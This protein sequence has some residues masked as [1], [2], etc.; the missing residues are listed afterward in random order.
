MLHIIN[1]RVLDVFTQTFEETELWIDGKQIAFRGRSDVLQATETYDAKGA[2]IAPGLID[3][4]L[5]IES[6]LLRP[7][8]LGRLLASHGI[9]TG[10][11]DPHELASVA[12]KDGISFMLADAE[13]SL[14]NFYFMLPSSVPAVDFE[15]AGAT[16]KAADLK[17]FYAHARVNGLA[18]VMDFP[19]VA[20]KESDMMQKIADAQ[21]LNKRIDGH[22][23]GLT[24]EQLA[25][26]RQAGITSDHEATSVAEAEDRLAAG[27]HIL[28][29]QGTVEQDER[30]L[31]P[32]V[33]PQNQHRFSFSTDDKTVSDIVARGSIDESVAIALAEGLP[34]EIVLTMA[35]YNAAQ[36]EGL[37]NVGALN[38]GYAADVIVFN[39]K[40]DFSVAQTMISGEWINDN[41][42]NKT[43]DVQ[44]LSTP[45][46]FTLTEQNLDVPIT[47][48]KVHVIG[49]E[50]NHITTS[51]QYVS[52][53]TD[54]G[55]FMPNQEFQKIM[56]AERYHD[57]GATTGII[58]GLD[59]KQ[60]AIGAT[61]AHDSHNV[62]IAGVDDAAMLKVAETLREM[63]GGLV[64]AI[65][66]ETVVAVPLAIGGLMS[67]EPYEVV[68]EQYQTLQAAFKEISSVTF[69][70]FITLSFMAL[71]VIPSLKITDQGLFDFEKFAFIQ[72]NDAQ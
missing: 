12:G 15:H 65:D 23:S 22:G 25:I 32:A 43:N 6:S 58:S 16:L 48:D 21:A 10:I 3:A 2:Y 35:S 62:I 56:V 40:E 47:S 31:L 70:P 53:P 14:T 71:P 30:A 60:G 34:L 42:V 28:I 7:A 19:A 44:P 4:H 20:A 66:A 18:E 49:I 63:N 52:V 57:L 61:V 9:T 17:E 27:M 13:A 46:N 55:M 1:A 69:D 51:H 29:R 37:Q 36:A 38:D 50:P 5:H 39:D 41:S 67:D 24:R 64:V 26:Y 8:E 59:L 33:T 11:A 72:L 45:L 54:N 68:A